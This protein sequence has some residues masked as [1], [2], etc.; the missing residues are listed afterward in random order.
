MKEA[1]RC[2]V[3]NAGD[4]SRRHRWLG[5]IGRLETMDAAESCGYYE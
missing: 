5:E 4:N 2:Y 1:A 3:I